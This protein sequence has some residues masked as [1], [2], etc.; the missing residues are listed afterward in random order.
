M[1]F[2]TPVSFP[3]GENC[4]LPHFQH[5][6][7]RF[8]CQKQQTKK[9]LIRL[10]NYSN[11]SS[12]KIH[13][14]THLVHLGKKEKK[15]KVVS[16]MLGLV[17]LTSFTVIHRKHSQRPDYQFLSSTYSSANIRYDHQLATVVLLKG[18]TGN[19][20]LGF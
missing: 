18:S 8:V 4:F 6:C 20:A 15:K 7:I 9:S 16:F 2:M 10:L 5:Q 12:V 19:R 17:L 11:R 14:E 1:A 3:Q 13:H